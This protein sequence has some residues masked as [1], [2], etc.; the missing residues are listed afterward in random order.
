[1]FNVQ[2][3]R[4]MRLSMA[5]DRYAKVWDAV[6]AD[7]NGLLERFNTSVAGAETHAEFIALSKDDQLDRKDVGGFC[8]GEIIGNGQ[9]TKA[10]I[11]GRELLTLDYD[12]IPKDGGKA[13]LASMRALNCFVIVHSTRKHTKEKPRLRL[14][15]PLNRIATVDEY[16]A[17]SRKVA[18]LIDIE[19]CD[20]ASFRENQLMFWPSH[21]G[22][23]Q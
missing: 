8:G 20:P 17:L 4:I 6:D 11:A 10:N 16:G 13:I 15:L 5:K 7:V 12:D 2:H 21:S 1:M 19:A 14:L 22:C 3:N 18:E 23:E 9:R